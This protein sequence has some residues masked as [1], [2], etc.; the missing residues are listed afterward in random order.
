MFVK[1][2]GTK[3]SEVELP[4]KSTAKE[5]ADKLHLNGPNQA[6]GVN[7]NGK[8]V[9]L[10]Y[11]LK[12]GDTVT[13]WSFDDPQGKEVFWHTSAHV[14][15]Q[16]ILRLWPNAQPTIGPPIENG[17][18]Y[19]FGNLTISDQDFEKIEEQMRLIIEENHLSKRE[20]F[21]NKEEAL[22]A[23]AHNP[24][25][26]E[27]IESFPE[28]EA[29]TGYRQG[30]FF[31]LCR[32]PHLYNLGKIKA[33][34]VLKT[35][36]AYWRGNPENAM[37]TRIYAIT[38]PDRKMLKDYL[39]S[40]EE[41]KKRDHKV[42]GVKLDLFSLKEE[43]PGMPFIHPKGTIVW[44]ELLAYLRQCLDEKNYIEIKTPTMMTRDLWELS[45]HWSNY[46]QNMFTSQ[47]EER[48]F[49]I[50]PMNCPGCMLYYR[51]QIHSYRELPLRVAEIGNVHRFEP[52][53]ALSGLFRVRSFHQDDAH[54]FMKPSDIRSE[55]LNVL[56]LAH[57]IYSTFG[58]TYRLELSTRPEKNTI[59]TDEEWAIA[60]EGLK[61]AL[62]E[63][64]RP[65]RINEGD[66]AFYGPKI[67]FHIQDAI[68]RT[69]Q[70]G[71]IQLDMALPEKFTLEYTAEDGSRQRPVM[72]HRA[73]FGSIER[74]F[75]ILIEHF[76]G[77]FP[78][79]IS[80]L[81]VRLIP[82]A[83]RHV[84]YARTLRK[85]FKEAGFHCDIDESNESVSKKVRNA[86]L[87]Q[88]NYMLTV[89]DQELQ[90]QTINLRTRENAVYGEIKPAALIA[91]MLEEKRTRALI[92]PYHK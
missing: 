53:G 92:S 12:A 88:I 9:D 4:E 1:V 43:A 69:W 13:F 20:S 16:A 8:A 73:I 23:F 21:A 40:V 7:V 52:S 51:S 75:G 5:L 31:D 59:G 17:F 11:A 29:L 91:S 18:Y 30:E 32:G 34:K 41:A 86:Q 87:S 89:G 6:L 14:L 81:Q 58:L 3:V 37:L 67:D 2:S 25:K 62:D 90:N 55:I 83:D 56:N 70:C 76:S 80:P 60:T 19:D 44:N 46:R 39:I 35:S 36:G 49:A 10:S 15:A 84:E 27:L 22:K 24:F 68:N 42:L 28:G 74:F 48:D 33:L 38:F 50:K 47:I 45:G 72:I 63:T 65:Y 71:T 79:W 82:V 54:I 77:R 57:E 64:G 78:L 66:G 61:N 26:V 85:Q